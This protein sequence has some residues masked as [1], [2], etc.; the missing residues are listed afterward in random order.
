M[1]EESDDAQMNLFTGD[2]MIY[3]AILTNDH[4]WDEKQVI[5]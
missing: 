5:E 1:R 2:N 4:E 3:R